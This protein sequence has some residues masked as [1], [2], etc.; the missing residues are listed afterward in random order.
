M[1]MMIIII[2][3]III[4]IIVGV[5]VGSEVCVPASDGKSNCR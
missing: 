3:I 2:M 5:Q 1:M 4:I